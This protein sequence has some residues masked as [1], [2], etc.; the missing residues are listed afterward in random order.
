MN[1][2]NLLSLFHHIHHENG[3]HSVHHCGGEHAKIDPIVNYHIS[4]CQ[5][6]KHMISVQSALGHAMDSHLDSPT[7]EVIFH[8]TCPHGGWHIESGTI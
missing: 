4:H 1:Q 5:C 2:Q 6:G 7:I 8:E 3:S